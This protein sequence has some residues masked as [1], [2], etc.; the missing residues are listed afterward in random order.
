[1][2]DNSSFFLPVITS[3]N[4]LIASVVFQSSLNTL[5]NLSNEQKFI[6]VSSTSLHHMQ[7]GKQTYIDLDILYACNMFENLQR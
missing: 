2:K 7:Y 4:V 6:C 3:S 5:I 1:M